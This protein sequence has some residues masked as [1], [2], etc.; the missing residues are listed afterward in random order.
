MNMIFK[1]ARRKKATISLQLN[2]LNNDQCFPIARKLFPLKLK[3][4]FFIEKWKV[5]HLLQTIFLEIV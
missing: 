1:I 4:T 2:Y 3:R 5:N